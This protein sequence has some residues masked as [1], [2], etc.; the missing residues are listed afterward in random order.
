MSR[1]E[2]RDEERG[3]ER[4]ERERRG[5][6]E[7]RGEEEKREGGQLPSST[8]VRL[9]LNLSPSSIRGRTGDPSPRSWPDR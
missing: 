3:K 6:D 2:E 7:E 4:E 1:K 5:L 9:Q 8:G